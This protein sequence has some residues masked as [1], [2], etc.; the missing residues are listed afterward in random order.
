M[1]AGLS[2]GRSTE[3][4]RERWASRKWT[5]R[6][7]AMSPDGK[8]VVTAGD[9]GVVRV[10]HLEPGVE[11]QAFSAHALPVT[12]VAVGAGGRTVYSGD[13]S[14]LVVMTD[15]KTGRATSLQGHD[16]TIHSIAVSHD[17]RLFASSAQDGTIRVWQAG[18][19]EPRS[20]VLRGHASTPTYIDFLPDGRLVSLGNDT[21]VRVWS[22]GA[23]PS[24]P[25]GDLASWIASRTSAKVAGADEVKSPLGTKGSDR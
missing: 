7:L 21:E 9:D 15:L 10:W 14:G 24:Y 18:A 20:V 11:H 5:R 12:R 2:P 25:T 17:G 8:V 19:G 16:G 1:T 3:K 4:R 13:Q 22:V 6:S 23:L